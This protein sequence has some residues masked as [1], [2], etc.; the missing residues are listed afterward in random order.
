MHVNALLAPTSIEYLPPGHNSQ[1]EM[2]SFPMVA[3]Y[4][5]AG[6]SVQVAGCTAPVVAKYLPAGQ[7]THDA[8]PVSLLYLPAAHA[9]HEVPVYPALHEQALLEVLP[10]GDP[11]LS[12]QL[13]Q[14]P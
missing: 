10:C 13:V 14:F 1:S 3:K 12:G 11:A 7:S 4:V 5:P 6:Q 8:F 2:A 9:E